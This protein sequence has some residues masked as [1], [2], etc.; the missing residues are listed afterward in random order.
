MN[1]KDYFAFTREHQLAFCL[2]ADIRLETLY[3][4]LRGGYIQKMKAERIIEASN[5]LI[6]RECL[7]IKDH[8]SC[9]KRRKAA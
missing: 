8:A 9:Y 3:R 7:K 6:K 2:K 5:G 1:L 4:Y